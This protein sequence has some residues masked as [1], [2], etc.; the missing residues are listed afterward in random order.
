MENPAQWRVC[1]ACSHA[2]VCPRCLGCPKH[3][4]RPI[5]PQR[6][7]EAPGSFQGREQSC[8]SPQA[9]SRREACEVV[10]PRKATQSAWRQI[11]SLAAAFGVLEAL[12][13]SQGAFEPLK[14]CPG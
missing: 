1:L 2:C 11:K 10:R 4:L 8:R 3:P 6:P 13:V 7:S 9:A 14:V 5:A 12:F